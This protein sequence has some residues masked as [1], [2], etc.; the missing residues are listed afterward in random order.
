MSTTRPGDFQITDRA[1]E[2]AKLKKGFKVLDVGCGEGDTVNHLNELGMEAE[3]IDM[4]LPKIAEAKE[5]YPQ[6]SVKFGDGEFLDEYMSFTFDAIF[7]ESV[8]S[9]IN[10]PEEAMHEAFCV[11]KKGGRLII[12]D[13]YEIDPDP[14]E[15]MAVKM[16]ADRQAR[17][18]HQEGDCE[19]RSLK[20]V[21][22]RYKGAFF[23]KPL[24]RQ[25]EEIGFRVLTFEDRTEDLKEYIGQGLQAEEKWQSI[26]KDLAQEA[27]GKKRELGYF[28]LI[29]QK[30]F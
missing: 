7:M 13:L 14:R 23:K 6:I 25:L 1:I 11:L 9:M 19:D 24:L 17:L 4:S 12:S 28:L 3:G 26:S 29:A 27:A 18:P 20:T 21:D 16:E 30:P 22:F 5:K 2:L 8:V 10:I 15:V